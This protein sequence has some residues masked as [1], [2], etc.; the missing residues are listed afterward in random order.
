MA[1]L[2]GS[3]YLVSTIAFCAVCLAI[4]AR[5]VRLSRGGGGRAELLLGLG[6]GLTGGLGYGLLIG[7]AIARLAAGEEERALFTAATAL[8][9]LLHDLGV[10]CVLAFVVQVFR[11]GVGWAR[12]LAAAMVAVLAVGCAGNGLAGGFAHGRPESVWYWVEFSVIG[13]YPLWASAESLA[14]WARMRRRR[15]LGLADP[16]VT[17][18]FLVWGVAFLLTFGA[19]WIISLPA[20]AGLSIEE[21]RRVSPIFMVLTAIVGSGSVTAQWLTYFPPRWY[22]ARVAGGAPSGAA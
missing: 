1:A 21:Q 17:N 5:L 20:I 22:R 7:A 16:L 13:T 8:G 18:R 4:G 2:A 11:P 6:I 10:A 19:I 9:R 12:A 3:L 14:Y 15:A